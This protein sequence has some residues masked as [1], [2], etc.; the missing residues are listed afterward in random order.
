MILTSGCASGITMNVIPTDAE[1][2]LPIV[3]WSQYQNESLS[4]LLNQWIHQGL[5]K[6]R[7]GVITGKIWRGKHVDKYL[8]ALDLDNWLVI[9]EFS[10]Y[11]DTKVC[12]QDI[13]LTETRDG[14]DKLHLYFTTYEQIPDKQVF[15]LV[16]IALKKLIKDNKFFYTD[17]INIIRKTYNLNANSITKFLEERCEIT[18]N[19]KDNILCTD[20]RNKYFNYCKE[21]HLRSKS[22]EEFGEELP[23][24][25]NRSRLK[26]AGIREY[27]YTGIKLKTETK[28]DF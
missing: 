7:V 27:Y 9:D 13:T 6:N 14:K 20:L 22:D 1:K 3:R 17:D 26:I 8:T 2:K 16:L 12:W 21:K 25:V 5:F 24:S 11:G 15:N 10:N 19:N 4:E 28:Q 18:G 23:D